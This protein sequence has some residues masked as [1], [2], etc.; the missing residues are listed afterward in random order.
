MIGRSDHT[1]NVLTLKTLEEVPGGPPLDVQVE[2]TSSTSVKIK[3]KPPLRE[4]HFGKIRG[5]YIGYKVAG[6]DD[7]FLYKNVDVVNEEYPHPASGGID[8]NP[9]QVSYITNLKRKTTYQIILQAY[10]NVGPGPRSDEV[11]ISDL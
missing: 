1:T 9:F 10:N 11:R 5:Y 2:T 3:W 7:P 8:S 6:M 4:L